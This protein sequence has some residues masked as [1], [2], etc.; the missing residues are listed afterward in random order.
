MIELFLNDPALFIPVVAFL[1]VV[2]FLL[3]S[4]DADNR[5]IRRIDRR[6]ERRNRR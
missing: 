4:I 5:E 3:F 2:I 1:V 6:L